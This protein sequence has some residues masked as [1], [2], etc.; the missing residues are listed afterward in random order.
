MNISR[1]VIA[2]LLYFASL[3]GLLSGLRRKQSPKKMLR[4]LQFT[5][6]FLLLYL[7]FL[8]I[9]DRSLYM[10]IPLFFFG[11]FYFFYR[12]DKPRLRNGWLFNLFLVSLFIYLTIIAFSTYS[13]I[14]I[15]LL[16][17]LGIAGLLVLLLGVYALVAFLI[18][19]SYL[20][21]KRESHSLPNL[22]TLILAL[23]LIFLLVLNNFGP[24]ILPG[25]SLTLLTIPT[26]ILVYFFIVFWNFLSISFIYQLNAPKLNQDYVI[27]LG[28]GL[29]NGETVSPLLAKRIERA[30][31]FYWKQSRETLSPPKFIMSGGQGADEKIPEAAAMKTYAVEQGIP[32]EE[33]L[34]ESQSTTTLEN[35]RFSKEIMDR[36]KPE[37][38][39][40]IFASN[41]YHIFRAGM[42]ADQVGLKADGI[43]AKTAKYYLPNAFL[44]E[45][46]AILVMKKR[47]HIVMCSLITLFSVLLAIANYLLTS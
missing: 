38:Y 1:D 18:G 21:F 31:A 22:L 46:V 24:S 35:M 26:M 25:W 47:V 4:A 43:G 9:Q 27:V 45:F 10:V 42:Y 11:L 15:G 36:E 13:L 5:G 6:G 16:G 29:S 44:R 20:V 17:L 19:N 34:M 40:A 33:I 2:F 3:I 14:I 7:L 41:N 23:G 32:A 30:I 39:Q 37:G 28:A 8:E 12:R